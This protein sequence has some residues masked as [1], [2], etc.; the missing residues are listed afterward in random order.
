MF[1][2][3]FFFFIY[4][5]KYFIIIIIIIIIIIFFYF[6]PVDW[7]NRCSSHFRSLFFTINKTMCIYIYRYMYLVPPKTRCF[8]K[9]SCTY[10]VSK[11]IA[12]LQKN[13]IKPKKA[14]TGRAPWKSL[15]NLKK[16]KAKNIFRDSQAL[17][18]MCFFFFGAVFVWGF[19]EPKKQKKV[20]ELTD[21]E[22]NI[23]YNIGISVCSILL[24]QSWC[25]LA[26]VFA[27]H[28]AYHCP[29]P[30][31]WT[32]GPIFSRIFFHYIIFNC[33]PIVYHI[34]WFSSLFCYY[35]VIFWK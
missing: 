35:T 14:N 15:K 20:V 32:S 7:T 22:D 23:G 28:H 8:I 29:V 25:H 19:G 26:F 10:S 6:F 11:S 30:L 16:Q 24:F 31:P 3:F 2:F 12:Y 4:F 5:K 18:N 1:F 33:F 21:S 13:G 34:S 9:V 27:I 17:W